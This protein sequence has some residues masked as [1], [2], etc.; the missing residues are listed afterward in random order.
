[1]VKKK[2]S[3]KNQELKNHGKEEE[4]PGLN[5]NKLRYVIGICLVL[6]GF[7]ILIPRFQS[8]MGAAKLPNPQE[9]ITTDT[10]EP[11]EKKPDQAVDF[12]V[13]AD[14]P[15]LITIDSINVSGYL[16]RVGLNTN[17]TIAVPNN[18]HY[19]GWYVDSVLPGQKGLSIIDG[20]VSGRYSDGVFKQLYRL[21]KSDIVTIEY[22]DG[23]R[24]KFEVLNVTTKPEAE[25]AEA[26]FTQ[27]PNVDYQLNLITCGGNFNSNTQTYDDR[28]IVSTKLMQ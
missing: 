12:Q 3:R 10:R 2:V 26:L 18:I 15:K 28:V 23:S 22:G 24:K 5:Q 4:I 27:E 1:M 7:C 25:A 19:A 14:Q 20:H 16:Q 11:S 21:R 13:A 9:T 17:K 8:K 6:V